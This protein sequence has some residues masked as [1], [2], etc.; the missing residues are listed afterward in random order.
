M[1]IMRE[2]E[3]GGEE[4]EKHFFDK[5]VSRPSQL[6]IKIKTSIISININIYI[7]THID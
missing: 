6:E 5:I 3:K 4:N 1:Q 2:K 7:H